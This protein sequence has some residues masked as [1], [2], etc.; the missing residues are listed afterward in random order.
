MSDEETT[1]VKEQTVLLQVPITFDPTRTNPERLRKHLDDFFD[2]LKTEF[3]D[4]DV[5]SP[6]LGSPGIGDVTVIGLLG[7]Y[8]TWIVWG[9]QRDPSDHPSHYSYDTEA[10]LSAF[11]DGVEEASGW[12]KYEQ[13][14]TEPEAVEHIKTRLDEDEDEDDG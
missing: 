10:L 6:T 11:M 8:E 4:D 5:V 14:D 1:E 13:F 2:V 3:W 7:T 12:M 9:S